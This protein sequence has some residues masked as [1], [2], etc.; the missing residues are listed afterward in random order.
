MSGISNEAPEDRKTTL[1]R[2]DLES[3]ELKDWLDSPIANRMVDM[4][5]FLP[6]LTS[7]S[8]E[9]VAHGLNS[10]FFPTIPN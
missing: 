8:I 2:T 4:S 5:D 6:S 7:E 9:Y 1:T 3:R 10:L